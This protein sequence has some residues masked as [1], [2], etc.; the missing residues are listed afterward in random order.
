MLL[1]IA[2]GLPESKID[3]IVD[4]ANDGQLAL[5]KVKNLMDKRNVSYKIIFMDLNMPNMG[6]IESTTLIR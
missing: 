3:Q 4:T 2:L 5:N 6:G 1:K